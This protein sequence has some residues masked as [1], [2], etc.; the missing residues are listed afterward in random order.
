MP[1]TAAL[2]LPELIERAAKRFAD[3]LTAEAKRAS[4]EADIRSVADRELARV[5]TEAG[6][7]FEARHEFTVASGRIDSVYDRVIIEFKNP[8]SASDRIGASLGDGGTQRVIAQIKSRFADLEAEHGQDIETLFGV[9]LDGHRIVFVRYRS[10]SWLEEAPTAL[11]PAS[12]AR[13]LWALFNLGA[14]GRPFSATYLARDFGGSSPSAGSMVRALYASI[15]NSDNPKAET[16]FA[17]WRS[18]FGIVCGYEALA[19][20][21]IASLQKLYGVSDADVSYDLLLFCAHTYYAFIMKLLSAEIV[22]V[23]HGL[24]SVTQKA[25]KSSGKRQLQKE[26]ADLEAGGIF[27]HIGIRNFLE[28]DLFSWYLNAW[29]EDLEKAVRHI[30]RE[31]DQYNLGSISDSPADTQDLLKD[32]YMEILPREVRHSLGEYYTPD[33][34]AD[35]LLDEVGFEGDFKR[36]VLDPACGS[37]TFLVRAIGRIRQKFVESPESCPGAEKGLLAVILANVVGFDI[38]PLAVL[39]SRT[40]ILI[41]VRDLIRFSGDIEL[42]VYLADSVSAPTEYEDLFTSA[43]P[44]ARVPCAATRPP[45]LLVPREVGASAKSV[46][47]F[48]QTIEHA[49]KV[50]LT[51]AEFVEDVRQTSVAMRGV[52]PYTEL[53]EEMTRLR[54]E[55]RD[56]IWARIIKNSFAPL[57]VGRFDLV[58]GNPPWVNWESLAPEYRRVSEEAWAHYGLTGPLPG[59]RRLQSSAHKT[60]VCILMTYVSA[61][62]YLN[63]GGKLGFVLPRT[64][65]QSQAG[66]WHFRS[67]DLPSRTGLRVERVQDIDALKPF[68]GQATNTSCV[69]TFATGSKNRYPVPWIRWRQKHARHALPSTLAQ[70]ELVTEKR[71]LV[72]EP[73]DEHQQQSPWI[74]G[75]PPILSLLRAAIGKSFYASRAREGLNTRGANGVYFVD[76]EVKGGTILVTNLAREGRNEEVGV[77]TQAIESQFLYPLLRG[78]DVQ[79]F[80]ASPK[81]YVVVPHS[82]ESPTAPIPFSRLPKR[83]RTFLATFEAVLSARRKF[84]NFDPS[85]GDWHGL[86][87]VLPATFSPYKVVWRENGNRRRLDR[88]SR[89]YGRHANKWQ[90]G[91]LAGP[92]AYNCTVRIPDRSGLPSWL[93]EFGSSKPNRPLVRGRN[94][95]IDAH[96]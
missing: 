38:N 40:N 92:Q 88:R 20:K 44:V 64:I 93:Y 76:A 80:K 74:V 68:R 6:I 90:E 31:F 52:K 24:P 71:K 39:A 86:Y 49:L 57:F 33:W 2:P 70:I 94:R 54:D 22:G 69:A 61:D 10:G 79:P 62:K 82:E 36:R 3:T 25:L 60:D 26:L 34:V 30:L 29:T 56:G 37:G 75:T 27:Q 32:L 89:K 28:G 63:K 45:F 15:K 91:R 83:T 19:S 66:G 53:Y 7:K 84:R 41:A 16:L 78:A 5:E 1:S 23:Y 58:V 67:F 42:P 77:E 12:A 46:Q 35:L 51:A 95:D 11:T 4:T 50:N 72:A 59:V 48:T 87:S 14:G 43:S 21:D 73:I 18:L 55:G 17:E 81:S 13:L 85:A 47:E 65:F 8:A 9:G 96:P